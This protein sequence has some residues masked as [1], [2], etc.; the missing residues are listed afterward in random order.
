MFCLRLS[1]TMTVDAMG[2]E[3]SVTLHAEILLCNYQ[4]TVAQRRDC[5][6]IQVLNISYEV[7]AYCHQRPV[8]IYTGLSPC[9]NKICEILDFDPNIPLESASFFSA[10]VTDEECKNRNPVALWGKPRCT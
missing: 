8:L 5:C 9:R 3:V 7:T 2:P 1:L 4:A 10:V 6:R